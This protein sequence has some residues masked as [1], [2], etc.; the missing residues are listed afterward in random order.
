[1]SLNCSEHWCETAGKRPG[2]SSRPRFSS[3]PHRASGRA[4]MQPQGLLLLLQGPTKAAV[5]AAL[6]SG[7]AASL[8]LAG[9]NPAF[10]YVERIP[11]DDAAFQVRWRGLPCC[12]GSLHRRRR[13][14]WRRRQQCANNGLT[15]SGTS[16]TA[17]TAIP[18][19][20][21]HNCLRCRACTAT[22]GSGRSPLPRRSG[23][24]ACVRWRASEPPPTWP[25]LSA[26]SEAWLG[27]DG[28]SL[29]SRAGGQM[30][31]A[32]CCKGLPQGN[33]TMVVFCCSA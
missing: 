31:R 17:V 3:G 30:G 15:S 14:R 4:T 8:A 28:R 2:G 12:R 23:R 25:S 16:W 26:A 9:R 24:S 5:G 20:P 1:M 22:R 19:T 10:C 27:W 18:H 33:A 13:R 29:C 11:Y 7:A 21:C 32:T 6:A